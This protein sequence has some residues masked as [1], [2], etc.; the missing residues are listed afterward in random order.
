[1]TGAFCSL[2]KGSNSL[3]L[4]TV[5]CFVCCVRVRYD[6]LADQG[7]LTAV[8]PD[9]DMGAAVAAPRP[10][11]TDAAPALGPMLG[12]GPVAPVAIPVAAPS[13]AGPAGQGVPVPVVGMAVAPLAPAEPAGPGVPVPIV[14]APDLVIPRYY[15]HPSV[16]TQR[17][18]NMMFLFKV[19]A[20]LCAATAGLCAF[21]SSSAAGEVCSCHVALL[22]T[23]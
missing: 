22:P 10:G 11:G 5:S 12:A 13:P 7:T 23:L 9:A 1:M 8:H 19:G 3:V 15:F 21:A 18:N 6:Y 2:V 17:F 14:A 16:I 4:P 20:H